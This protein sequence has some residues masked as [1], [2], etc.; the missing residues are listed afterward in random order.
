MLNFHILNEV[1][2]NFILGTKYNRKLKQRRLG[3]VL[4]KLMLILKI[5]LKRE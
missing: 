1:D 2:T 3:G 5:Y 4:D